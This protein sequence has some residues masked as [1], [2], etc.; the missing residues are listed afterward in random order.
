M[1][2]VV[3]KLVGAV[4]LVPPELWPLFEESDDCA[5]YLVSCFGKPNVLHVSPQFKAITG[6][7]PERFKTEGNQFWFTLIHPADMQGV[8]ARIKK[9]EHELMTSKAV[10]LSP[11]ELE[12]RIKR[13]DGTWCWIQDLK[14]IISWRDGIKDHILGCFRDISAAKKQEHADVSRLLETQS[15]S[16][17]LLEVAVNYQS[18]T[19]G[20]SGEPGE[21]CPLLSPRE[22]EVLK[23][24][25]GGSSSKQIAAELSISENT[26][27][28]HRR[29]LLKKFKVNNSTGLLKEARR[30]ALI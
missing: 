8:V 15:G 22:N 17:G 11:L 29:N 4:A 13:A 27:E 24:V 28:T 21:G 6:Y 30:L 2:S 1:K 16:H 7:E 25:A 20:L 12:Y 18:E 5:P 19:P 9:A 10:P 3:K 26:V 14:L 23:L